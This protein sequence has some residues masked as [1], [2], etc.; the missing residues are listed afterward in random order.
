MLSGDTADISYD[1]RRIGDFRIAT[2]EIRLDD[3]ERFKQLKI[4]EIEKNIWD[5][6]LVVLSDGYAD[7]IY[8]AFKEMV[9]VINACDIQTEFAWSSIPLAPL[10]DDKELEKD[11]METMFSYGAVHTIW[12][13]GTDDEVKNL[14]S[15]FKSNGI[16][17]IQNMATANTW[18]SGKID[19]EKL[20]NTIRR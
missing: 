3:P 7:I 19:E 13:R 12:G 10:S 6:T 9:R 4:D 2:V 20:I 8:Q 15:L 5:D 18:V 11:R 17:Q 14:L 1:S 16:V